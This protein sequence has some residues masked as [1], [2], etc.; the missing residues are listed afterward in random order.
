MQAL[1]ILVSVM[2]ALII[3]GT[4]IVVVTIAQR[5]SRGGAAPG[6]GK[7]ALV[8][9]QGCHVVEMTAAGAKLALRLGD[10]PGCQGIVIVDP[11]TGRETGRLELLAQP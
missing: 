4:V 11:E 5:M 3:V 2:G 9:P 10:G 8:L 1:K 7:A 6:F